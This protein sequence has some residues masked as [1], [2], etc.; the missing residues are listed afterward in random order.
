MKYIAV[1]VLF[2]LVIAP[3]FA[4][5]VVLE[6]KNFFRNFD[7]NSASFAYQT[8]GD[9]S[10]TGTEVA[11]NTYDTKTIQIQSKTV[12]EA[13]EVIVEGRSKNAG[14][15]STLKSAYLYPASGNVVNNQVLTITDAIDFLRVGVRNKDKSTG[16]S[17]INIDGIFSTNQ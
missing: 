14:Q 11:C 17:F 4:S 9:T 12:G 6:N 10:A 3:V 1:L 2:L 8:D 16:T 13:V 7:P 5:T 15:Y